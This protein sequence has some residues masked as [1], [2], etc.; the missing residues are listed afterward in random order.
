MTEWAFVEM[1]GPVRFELTTF[2]PPDGRANQAAPRPD[3][4]VYRPIEGVGASSKTHGMGPGQQ[5]RANG[6][7]YGR[8]L[9]CDHEFLRYADR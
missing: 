5:L 2:R 6:R 8:F 9:I 4:A 1:V 3:A 7:N